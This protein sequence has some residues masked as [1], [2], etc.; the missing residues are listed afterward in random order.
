MLTLAAVQRAADELY[1]PGYVP[2]VKFALWAACLSPQKRLTWNTKQAEALRPYVDRPLPQDPARV[3]DILRA[4]HPFATSAQARYVLA[5]EQAEREGVLDDLEQQP[6]T[7]AGWLLWR[8]AATKL[9]GISWKTASFA[10]LLLWP[11]ECPLIPVDTHVC[12]R[13]GLK[14]LKAALGSYKVYRWVERQVLHEWYPHRAECP[15]PAV[16]HW[17]KWSE[18]RQATGDEPVSDQPESHAGLSPYV[19]YLPAAHVA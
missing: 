2:S 16:W 12:D 1:R 18:W 14:G 11:N 5:I 13:L 4:G 8:H 15:S 19:I 7:Y 10:A 9:P 3:L 17:Y 6:T